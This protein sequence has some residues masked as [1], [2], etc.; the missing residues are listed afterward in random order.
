MIDDKPSD[1]VAGPLSDQERPAPD[2]R[3]ASDMPATAEAKPA[4]LSLAVTPKQ[5]VE[6]VSEM[7]IGIVNTQLAGI[8]AT[9]GA[10]GAPPQIIVEAYCRAVGKI[11]GSAISM[12][13]LV[14]VMRVREQCR[15][16]FI[17]GMKG[18]QMKPPPPMTPEQMKAMGR[19]NGH[20]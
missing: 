13:D 11:V 14:T 15:E 7:L 19:L 20:Q 1:A 3:G 4:A 9:T 10:G 18:V 2:E 6:R 17:D 5:A 8:V 16:A 12:G